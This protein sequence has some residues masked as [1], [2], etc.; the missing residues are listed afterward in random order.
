MWGHGVIEIHKA[1]GVSMTVTD[2]GGG[3]SK[4]S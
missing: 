4:V 3:F 1:L 2:G